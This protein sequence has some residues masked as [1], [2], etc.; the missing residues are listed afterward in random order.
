MVEGIDIWYAQFRQTM[1][2]LSRS[3]VHRSRFAKCEE[4]NDVAITDLYASSSDP[5]IY[6]FSLF[7]SKH[8]ATSNKCQTFQASN[9]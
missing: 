1:S 9:V 3:I 4:I 6:P 8:G 5:D 2:F 7:V